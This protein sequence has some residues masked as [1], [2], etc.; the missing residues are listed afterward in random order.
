M[1]LSLAALRRAPGWVFTAA[2]ILALGIAASVALF[3]VVEA[4]LLRPPMFAAPEDL[5]VLWESD[6]KRS[7]G[8]VE[9]SWA[10]FQELRRSSQALA[11]VAS[12]SSVNLDFALL[13]GGDPLQVEGVSVTANYFDLLGVRPVLGRALIAADETAGEVASIVISHRLWVERFGAQASVTERKLRVSGQACRVVG[14]M[15]ANF[16]FPRG[17]DIWTPQTSLEQFRDLRVLK[18][19]ARRRAGLSWDQVTA[20]LNVVIRRMD[21]ALP[22]AR[23]G[24]TAHIV[25]MDKVLFGNARTGLWTLL[26]AA[27]LLL[28]T[29]CANVANLFLARI[30]GRSRELAIREAL[31]ARRSD[32]VKLLLGESF[33]VALLAGVLGVLLASWIVTLAA[34]FGPDDLA[35][36]AEASVSG[37]AMA[38]ALL[39]VVVT[40]CLVGLA[41]FVSVPARRLR[42]GL[43]VAEVAVSLLLLIGCGLVG[44]SLWN[45]STIDPG[46]Q[47]EGI[48][49]FRVTL[50]GT[51][52]ASQGG[53]KKFYRELLEKLRA[54]PG[55]DS[56]A[57]VLIRPLG[58][59][60]GWDSPFAVEGQT[61]EEQSGNPY[62]NYEAV[63]P[64]Y[65][66]TMGM[67]VLA[68]REFNDGDK[69][70]VV[71]INASA[72]RRFFGTLDAIGKQ[73]K[74]GGAKE[75][76]TVVGVVKDAHYRE[77]E[78][79]RV[80]LYVPVEQRAQHRSDFVVRTTVPPETLVEPVRRAVL[81]L[82]AEQP[83]SNVTTMAKLVDGALA[84]P[85]FL[86]L[87]FGFFGVA[88]VLL[89]VAGLFAVLRFVFAAKER[90][91]A[92]RMAIGATPGHLRAVVLRFGMV[93]VVT[94]VAVGLLVAGWTVRFLE[95][96]LF[97]VTTWTPWIWLAG[98]GVLFLASLVAALGPAWRAGRVEPQRLLQQL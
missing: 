53:R 23:R 30:A 71:M 4:V 72:A 13:D 3:S 8:E 45:L 17:A 79:A 74:L 19:V 69:A 50:T 28:L 84:R 97:G 54:M 55:V 61:P 67:P 43:I 89:T 49:T 29:A 91:L 95:P 68:G 26:A 90:D 41:P 7:H 37:Q 44:R 82:N 94:G 70:G 56:A 77:W 57:A 51:P 12:V 9:I 31:G 6:P 21:E 87:L 10:R 35:G 24:F 18:L 46:F 83:I 78:A 2:S 5:A 11:G 88:A 75:W 52:A 86:T 63:S 73:I 64:G 59:S 39:L 93:R 14:V 20:D 58:G 42:D 25:P 36:L 1:P 27:L 98:I 47:R 48:L 16:A 80:D 40:S 15:P 76:L 92:I 33:A 62:A 81:A 60:V 32:L 85:R 66:G 34:R 65:F 96:L 22:E 38:L